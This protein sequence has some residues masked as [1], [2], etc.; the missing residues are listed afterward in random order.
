MFKDKSLYVGVLTLAIPMMVQTGITNAVGLVDN[1][2]VGT[3]GT[4]SI[5]AVSIASQIVFVY[6]IGVFGG[7]SG[8]GIFTAQYYGSGDEEGIRKTFRLK[9]WIALFIIALGAIVLFAFSEQ[10][11]G[12]YLKGESADIDAALTMK[13][14]KE[15]LYIMAI[16]LVPFTVAQIYADTLREVGD[17]FKP[18]VA[19]VCSVVGDIVFNYLLIF[20]KFGFPRLEIRGAAIATVIGRIFEIL[21]II[22]W[23]HADSNRHGFLKGV[24]STMLLPINLVIPILKKA[25]PIFVNEIL[26]A[27]CLAVMTMCYSIR[28]LEVVAGLQ[29]SNVICN[30]MNV[31]FISLGG[32]IGILVG[33]TLGAGNFKRA[34]EM[35]IK[36]MW[37][38]TWIA[39]GLGL[40][41]VMLSKGFPMLYNTTPQIRQ[42][43]TY[44][45]IITACEFPVQG[46]LNSLYFTLRSGGKTVI[47]FIFDSVFNLVVSIPLAYILCFY[48]GLNIL[49]VYFIVLSADLIKTIIGLIL[50]KKGIWM[51]NLVSGDL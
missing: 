33:Q 40:I 18:M 42:F 23:A 15:Y 5:T 39:L 21:V 19:G 14:A 12:M 34:Q 10:I 46:A 22:I 27:G 16:G 49:L 31:G 48:T 20:G 36:L 44:F 35:A 17:S 2:M 30:L 1:L 43:A 26:W 3:L 45:I 41:L 29:I 7:L 38:S 51:T 4:E 13:L 50:V 9:W 11:L 25:I 6:A 47:T 8:V 28:G 37:F 32:A 24:Y